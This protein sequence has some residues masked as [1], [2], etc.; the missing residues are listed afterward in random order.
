MARDLKLN[1]LLRAIDKTTGPLKKITKGSGATADALKASREELKKLEKAQNQVRGFRNV[2]RELKDNN[3][4]LQ[5]ARQRLKQVRQAID[6]VGVPTKELAREHDRAA[7][8]VERLTGKQTRYLG[9]MRDAKAR[10]EEA[11]ISTR[12]LSRHE[13]ELGERIRSTNRQLE[14]QQQQLREVARRQ[15]AA[16]DAAKR[17]HR[18]IGRANNM[19]GVGFSGVATGT[20]TALPILKTVKD[21]SSFEDAMLGVAKQV[22]GAR[23]ANG[24]LTQTY[25]DIADG[26]KAMSRELPSTTTEL[27]AITEGAARMGVQGKENLLAFTRTTAMAANAFELPTGQIG[28]DMGKL[29]A[30]YKIPIKNIDEL[31]DRLNYLDDNALSKGGDIIDVMKRMAGVS[32]TVGMSYQDA[33]ALGSA[34]LSSG[35]PREVAGM[36]GNA[37]IRELN[38][39]RMQP[40]RF[41][42][43]LSTLGLSA[44]DVQDSMATDATGTIL[45]VLDA[46]NRL[47]KANQLTVMTQLF[48]KEYGDDAAKLAQNVG[49]YRRQLELANSAAAKGSMQRE[50]DARNQTLSA[51]AQMTLNRL[52]NT[53]T[54]LGA[55]LKATLVD[56]LHSINDVLDTVSRF[57]KE[58]PA[59]VAT[60]IKG[61]AAFSA[62]VAAG[63]AATIMIAS[64]IGPFATTRFALEYLG[65]RAKGADSLLTKLAKGGFRTIGQAAGWLGGA[66][67]TVSIHVYSLATRALPVLGNALVGLGKGFVT[68]A[69]AIGRAGLALLMNP[70]TWI[71]LG[72]VA[73]VA[74]L[75]GAAYLIYK[76]WGAISEWFAQ[77]WQDVKDAFSNGIGGVAKLLLNWS[78]LGLLYRGITAALDKL[79]VDI[80]DKF[81]SLGG[82]IVDG[83]IGGLTSKI[84]ALKEKVTS[85]AGDV[86]GWFADKLGI[87]SPSRVFAQLGGYTVD[88]LNQGL[89]RQRDEPAQRVAEIAR[90]LQ[91]AGAGLAIGAA[92]LPAIADVPIDHRPPMA[93][94]SGNS[95]QITM[96]DIHVHAAPGMDERAL[97]RYVV[98]EVQRALAAAERDAGA[99]RRSALYD[100]D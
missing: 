37:M 39:A 24:Q 12:D 54:E 95:V 13:R 96:G 78:P 20:A 60:L 90:R 97:A 67:R 57:A 47:P 45:K 29:A 81:R 34:F 48:G 70:V 1:I 4:E 3:T 63:G 33:A 41:Q 44:G 42:K 85:I 7:K 21:F 10:L 23:D 69:T 61:A 19:R 86:K 27:A 2:S 9:K 8:A 14:T 87:H 36:A 16:G 43:G 53:N 18:S 31:G 93:S 26:L 100:Y 5:A 56:L 62:L 32:Q 75:A 83:L 66:F 77:R 65:L 40:A 92:S 59:L 25:Y 51:Q 72:I 11:G 30:L 82:F 74:A 35:A 98:A 76:N 79:G 15:K 50:S 84:A 73:A 80:P 38:I 68:L 71:V 55:L 49:E 52:F 46:V 89:D 58:N 17:Y 22:N 28:E 99:R 64:L 88:G 6:A 91:R 94:P